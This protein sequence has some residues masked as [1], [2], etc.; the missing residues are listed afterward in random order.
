MIHDS[1]G[2]HARYTS[3]LSSVLRNE[4]VKMY[5]ENDVLGDLYEQ[6][7]RQLEDDTFEKLKK[8]LERGG[9]ALEVVKRSEYFFC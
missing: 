9:L 6:L 8:P 1:F 2:V 7:G 5:E 4:F 3:R